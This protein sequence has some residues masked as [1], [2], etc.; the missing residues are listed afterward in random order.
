M[1]RQTESPLAPLRAL[2]LE[3]NDAG[4]SG[5]AGPELFGQSLDGLPSL[6]ARGALQGFGECRFYGIRCRRGW[7]RRWP[8]C[9]CVAALSVAV[10]PSSFGNFRVFLGPLGVFN[11]L[12]QGSNPCRPTSFN[13]RSVFLVDVNHVAE[14]GVVPGREPELAGDGQDRAPDRS[15]CRYRCAPNRHRNR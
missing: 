7:P 14:A 1:R 3:A 10:T 12:V 2:D 9:H 13:R 4:S 15:S 8:R 11:P 6:G 5:T